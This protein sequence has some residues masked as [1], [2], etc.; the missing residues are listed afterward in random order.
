MEM[1]KAPDCECPLRIRRL[2]TKA[3]A[4]RFESG[5]FMK[6]LKYLALAAVVGA[7]F[8]MI[9]PR[10]EAQVSVNIGVA[11]ECPYGY[12][13]YPP[14][15]CAPWGYYG[16]EWFGGNGVFI[17]AGPWFHGSKDFDRTRLPGEVLGAM[18]MREVCRLRGESGPGHVQ[19]GP[20]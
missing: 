17:G 2:R 9:T 13:D 10:A 1:A 3:F 8:T 4:L 6:L 12:Y 15:D 7:C 20:G 19:G 14:Y 5:G 11:P 18:G 16:P